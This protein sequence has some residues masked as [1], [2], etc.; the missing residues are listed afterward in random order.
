MTQDSF[1]L[2]SNTDVYNSSSDRFE[3]VQRIICDAVLYFYNSNFM[4]F[5][6]SDWFVG[7]LYTSIKSKHNNLQFLPL[8]WPDLILLF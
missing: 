3:E 5:L 4:Y 2:A 7:K 1:G 6:H 8:K